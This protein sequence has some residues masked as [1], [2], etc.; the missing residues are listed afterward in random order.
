VECGDEC[1]NEIEEGFPDSRGEG[2]DQCGDECG[3]EIIEATLYQPLISSD[4]DLPAS[5][6]RKIRERQKLEKPA[7]SKTRKR[8]KKQNA[9]NQGLYLLPRNESLDLHLHIRRNGP[10]QPGRCARGVV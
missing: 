10:L 2:S 6:T 7:K 5:K 9:E 3:N 8:A 1:G 4:V